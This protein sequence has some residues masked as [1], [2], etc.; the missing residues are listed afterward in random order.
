MTETFIFRDCSITHTHT[1]ETSPFH[2]FF[3]I[4]L[5][6]RVKG[7]VIKQGGEYFFVLSPAIISEKGVHFR[8]LMVERNLYLSFL[9]M[10]RETLEIRARDLWRSYLIFFKTSFIIS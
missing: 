7:G 10:C 1:K 8:D 9:C 4:L 2:L 3:S 5:C 6:L